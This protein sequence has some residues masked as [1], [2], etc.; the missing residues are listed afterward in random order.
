MM[1]K[2]VI[3]VGTVIAIMTATLLSTTGCNK[4]DS[5]DIPIVLSDP[6]K[7][8]NQTLPELPAE[9]D[10]VG[11]DDDEH[12]DVSANEIPVTDDSHSEPPSGEPALPSLIVYDG[13]GEFWELHALL[14]Q[15][16]EFIE[17]YLKNDD[18]YSPNGLN[19]RLDIENLFVSLYDLHFPYLE[20][21]EA[22]STQLSIGY[23]EDGL[24]VEVPV[25]IV[26]EVD[27]VNYAFVLNASSNWGNRP[28]PTAGEVISNWD[29]EL[30]GQL[31]LLKDEDSVSVYFWQQTDDNR[32]IFIMNVKGVYT[33]ATVHNAEDKQA[34]IDGILG[35]YFSPLNFDKS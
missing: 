26:Y 8:D 15:S 4:D 7:T 16:D 29:E 19:T 2:R 21:N 5:N 25:Y 14:E 30:D 27:G 1:Q 23:T 33:H 10:E 20:G 34:A 12:I 18:R 35:F 32:V 11:F 9:N 13:Y 17:D 28:G 31:E 6:A 3:A 22:A 24:A